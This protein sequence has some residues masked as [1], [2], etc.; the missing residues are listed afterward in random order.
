MSKRLGLIAFGGIVIGVVC[1]GVAVAVGGRSVLSHLDDLDFDWG[2]GPRCGVT[3]AGEEGTRELDWTAGDAVQLEIPADV[4]YV[5]GQGDK[6]VIQGDEA[7]LPKVRLDDRGR[8]RFDCRPRHTGR[9]TVT[10]P[11]RDFRSYSVKGSGNVTLEGIDQPTLEI[12]VAGRSDLTATGKTDRLE[13]NLAG[14]GDAKLGGLEVERAELNIAGHGDTE[15]NVRDSLEVNIAGHGDVRLVT[16]PAHIETSIL[17][18]GEIVHPNGDVN[19]TH[20]AGHSAHDN[21]EAPAPGK[22]I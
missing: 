11:G 5:R 8:I 2:G 16:E 9:L 22:G 6:L 14:S 21:D 4:R 17:G 12:N 15:V 19:R 20:G 3:L 18:A 7:V 1:M 10:L 13:Y